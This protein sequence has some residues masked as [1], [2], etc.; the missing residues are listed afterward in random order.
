MRRRPDLRA[1][2]SPATIAG[3]AVLGSIAAKSLA[4]RI[5]EHD[6][7]WHMRAGELIV[8]TRSIPHADVFSYTAAGSPWVVQSWL[9]DVFLHGI[10]AAFGPRGIIVWRALMLV[11]IYGLAARIMVKDA[12]HSVRTWALIALATYAGV[13]GW[14]ERPNLFSYLLIVA[15]V[16]LA[17]DS[18]RRAWWAVPLIALWANLHAMV[19]LGVGVLL[20][21]A[22]A[23]WL[24]VVTRLDD[25]RDCARRATLVAG[26]GLLAS[27]INPSGP[28]IWSFAARLTRTASLVS[29]EWASP[30][31]HRAGVLPFLALILVAAVVMA[32]ARDRITPTELMLAAAFIGLGLFSERN[33]PASGLVLG[34]VLARLL[35]PVPAG[36][37]R[38]AA[39]Q[40]TPPETRGNNL[41][42]TG[43]ALVA[44]LAV[45]AL[46]VVQRFPSS[47]DLVA[48]A[49]RSLPVAAIR[50][51]PREPI[52]LFIDDRWGGLAIYMR[53]PGVHVAIDGR[54]E[55]YGKARIAR[56]AV[57]LAGD[58]TWL[59]ETCTTHAIVP[60]TSGLAMS[61]RSD[62]EWM[63]AGRYRLDSE[64]AESFALRDPASRARCAG[65]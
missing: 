64:V 39:E 34:L 35:R 18:E 5:A 51:L 55:V 25:A 65:S 42:V 14:I 21:L 16:A 4:E 48:V 59:D 57:T 27:F 61:L 7:W 45:L 33:L 8:A 43:P 53:W 22:G 12:G 38:E 2:L 46:I 31:F 52:R 24:A 30:D 10:D 26:A 17:R 58:H 41:S 20:L 62:P 54:A 63:L 36:D 40:R 19:V 6:L 47:S 49:D 29:T 28:A 32:Y 44:V 13:L 56:Y 15:V 60:E 1:L 9:A 3:V 50:D 37:V 11:A 23:R